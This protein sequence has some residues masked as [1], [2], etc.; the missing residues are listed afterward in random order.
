[1]SRIGKKPIAL[2][3]GIKV[4]I[5]DGVVSVSNGR[6]TLTQAV[7]PRIRVEVQDGSLL[8]SRSGENKE[9]RALHG[10]YRSL[11][12]NM[13]QGLSTGFRKNLEIN[14]TGFR[15]TKAGSKL[16][17]TL[18]Y[19]H[20][21]EIEEPQG[22]TIE[23]PAVNRIVVRGANKQLVGETAARI[24]A[25]RVPDPYKGKGIKYD[26]EVLRLREGKTGGR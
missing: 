24:R 9:D 12:A 7:D 2:P 11:I 15:A 16:T 13:V 8:V 20:P 5:T 21:I 1:M 25:L 22:I 4:D 6:E 17:L 14:G 23:V 10:L 3:E 18:G 19:S 26:N